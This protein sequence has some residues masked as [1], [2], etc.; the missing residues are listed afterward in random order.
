MAE[1]F[2]HEV[3][4]SLWV[5]S[6]TK[7]VLFHEVGAA[8]GTFKED[9]ERLNTLIKAG[10]DVVVLVREHFLPSLA[11]LFPSLS[12]LSLLRFLSCFLFSICLILSLS[13]S[14][15]VVIWIV[16][17]L[18]RIHLRGTRCI[19]LIWSSWSS[20]IARTC[21]SLEGMVGVAAGSSSAVYNLLTHSLLCLPLLVVTA[22]QA[23]NLIDAGV[24]GLRVGMGSGSICITQV[25]Y[26]CHFSKFVWN[27]HCFDLSLSLSLPLPLYLSLFLV[28]GGIGSGTSPRNCG[29]QSGR[30]CPEIWHP[31]HCW[32]WYPDGRTHL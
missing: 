8:V 19:R 27:Y 7:N 25:S 15:Y 2:Q 3:N 12:F 16:F 30:V 26:W 23:K 21:R 4:E 17:L 1:H 13:L 18:H 31:C 32:W 10:M 14:E 9:Q 5:Y 11:H 20:A 28:S 24:D 22:Q 29:L 6:F